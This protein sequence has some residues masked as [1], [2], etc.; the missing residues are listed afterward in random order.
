MRTTARNTME[1][2]SPPTDDIRKR[3]ETVTSTELS[4]MSFDHD[5]EV[6]IPRWFPRCCGKPVLY[7]KPEALGWLLSVSGQTTGILGVGTF[8]IPALIYYGRL[9]AGCEVEI[10]EGESE[11]PECNEKAFGLKPSSMITTM[12]SVLSLVVAF[13]TPLLG[14]F[15]DYTNHRRL[16]GR[17]LSCCYVCAVLPLC[18]I[19]ETT[20]FPLTIC[21]LCMVITAQTLSLIL[22]AY[23]PDLTDSEEELNHM[24]K[25]FIAVP[26]LLSMV[27]IMVVIAISVGMGYGGQDDP[28]F[29]AR[30]AALL[31]AFVLGSCFLMA[32]GFLMQPRPALNKLEE[33]QILF[34][35]GFQQIGRTMQK[36]YKTNIPLL[37]FYGAVALGDVKPLT[38]IGLTFISSHQQF[39]SMD[40]GI[41]SMIMLTSLVPGAFLSSFVCR[42]LNPV[43][44]SVIAVIAFISVTI[45]ASIFLTGPNQKPLTYVFIACWGIVGGWKVTSTQMLVTAIIPE[46]QDAELMGFYLFADTCLSWAPPLIFTA[47]NE[48]GMSERAGLSCIVIFWTIALFAYWKMGTY[49]DRVK[50]ANRLVVPTAKGVA[51]IAKD[52]EAMA[53]IAPIDTKNTEPEKLEAEQSPV[54]MDALAKGDFHAS[55]NLVR[56]DGAHAVSLSVA[57]LVA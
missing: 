36:L 29:Q 52:P 34:F 23:L 42:K 35:Q 46:G 31:G 55:T 3:T 41:A 47:M 7:G 12:M 16:F 4:A 9:E 22:H 21:I 1:R 43:R 56:V 19:S 10:P 18:F 8:M 51:A 24:T 38:S 14:A 54:Q 50:A 48:A 32:W 33:G 39:T 20:W 25:T 13:L 27:F 44:S 49:D 53:E 17:I 57:A 11:L 15:V 45:G 40:I 6:V 28:T 2:P 37:W 5:G 26:G 30:I